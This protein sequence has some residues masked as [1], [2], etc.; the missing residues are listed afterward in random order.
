M[1]VIAVFPLAKRLSFH[2][3][4]YTKAQR[5]EVVANPFVSLCLRVKPIS[6]LDPAFA[7]GMIK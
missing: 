4:F 2:N 1:G 3:N 7:G 5:H 6:F